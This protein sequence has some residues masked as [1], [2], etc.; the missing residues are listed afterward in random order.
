M[1]LFQNSVVTKYLQAQKKVTKIYFYDRKMKIS[2]I[3]LIVINLLIIHNSSLTAQNTDIDKQISI[4]TELTGL[5]TTVKITG[6][7]LMKEPGLTSESNI[8]LLT[9]KKGDLYERR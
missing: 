5:P 2:L 8:I 7:Q 4:N 1:P 9:M 3:F 6:S